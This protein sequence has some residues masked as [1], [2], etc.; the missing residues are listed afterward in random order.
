MNETGNNDPETR[1][2]IGPQER[3]WVRRTEQQNGSDSLPTT[4]VTD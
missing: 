1:K 2:G 4:K 3:K